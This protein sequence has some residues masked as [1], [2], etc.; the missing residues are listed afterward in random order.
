MYTITNTMKNRKHKKNHKHAVDIAA[1]AL[2]GFVLGAIVVTLPNM[3]FAMPYQRTYG[4]STA[5]FDSM[6]SDSSIMIFSPPATTSSIT[7]SSATTSS[8]PFSPP[9]SASSVPFSPPS[10]A[11]SVAFS[12]P[13][14]DSSVAFSPPSSD[15]SVAFSPPSSDSSVAFSPPSSDSSVAFSPPS[16]DSSVAFSPPSSADPF[17]IADA[18]KQS[19]NETTTP[20]MLEMISA[21]L[22]GPPDVS[23]P[24]AAQTLPA[25]LLPSQALP[26][27]IHLPQPPVEGTRVENL[28]RTEPALAPQQRIEEVAV[29]RVDE[30]EERVDD[31]MHGAADELEIADVQE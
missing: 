27:S 20:T 29:Q 10:S 11:S 26:D 12:P 16:S 21:Y 6:T 4:T 5:A 31:I 14:S 8:V 30:P 23:A 17:A 7:F 15:S 2:M 28:P 19:D 1:A 13:S 18:A 9:S 3:E 24:Q 22:F 25:S